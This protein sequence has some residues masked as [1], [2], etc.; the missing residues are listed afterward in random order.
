M[1]H[2]EEQYEKLKKSFMAIMDEFGESVCDEIPPVARLLYV[3]QAFREAS[4]E[5]IIKML[6]ESISL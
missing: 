5:I 3:I 4:D 6:R 2:Y 1:E